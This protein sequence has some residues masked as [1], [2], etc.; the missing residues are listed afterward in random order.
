MSILPTIKN[1][2]AAGMARDAWVT[3]N[4]IRGNKIARYRRYVDGDFDANMTRE[5]QEMLRVKQGSEFGA[6]YCD[7]VVQTMADRLRVT[8]IT[9]DDA[10]ATTW[11]ANVLAWNRF[12]GLQM[13]VHESAIRDGDSYVMVSY[14]NAAQMPLLT[15]ELAYDG[16]EGMLV[17]HERTDQSVI[18]C[19]IK[20]WQVTRSQFADTLRVNFYYPDR[21][22]RYIAPNVGGGVLQPFSEDGQP[23]VL[24]WT[25]PD[26]EPIGVPVVQ[27]SN[28]KRGDTGYGLSEIESA[29]PLQDALNRTLHSMI[30]AAEL[31]AFQVRYVVGF[32]PPSAIVPGMI[33]SINAGMD[34]ATGQPK[35]PS[36]GQIRWF[37][38]IRFGAFDQGEIVPFIEQ[39]RFLVDQLRTTTRTP[40]AEALG[41]G[42]SGESRK[43]AEIGLIGKCER[44]Q[45]KAGN[46]W[47]NVTEMAARVARAYSV[48]RLPAGIESA[49]WTCRWKP[50]ALRDEFAL[51]DTILKLRDYLTP[52]MVLRLTAS[53]TGLDEDAIQGMINR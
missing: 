49:R 52:E 47:E 6:N 5:M 42:V 21:I 13:D 17:V 29:I 38:S 7:T 11:A 2:L 48:A 31:S 26:G 23:A 32:K 45:V 14:D 24:E 15:H 30:M 50:A 36:E 35:T 18:A 3:D 16:V 9:A 34:A 46:A 33:L 19:A 39:A 28:R 53:A 12:D 40:N 37:D 51:V 27:F 41:A 4:R 22:E 8:A 25:L 10:A 43:Q 44:F 1:Q 20:V